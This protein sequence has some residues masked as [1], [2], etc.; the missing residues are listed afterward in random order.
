MKKSIIYKPLL[1]YVIL[2]FSFT[3]CSEQEQTTNS[4]NN[5]LRNST[6]EF[7]KNKKNL[8][9]LKDSLYR[10]SLQRR[11][12]TLWGQEQFEDLL[13]IEYQLLGY[14]ENFCPQGENRNKQISIIHNLIG[15]IYFEQE[16]YN[17][18]KQSYDTALTFAKE[19]N[20]PNQ[21][22][23]SYFNIGK[24]YYA[25]EQDFNTSDSLFQLA[26][27][28]YNQNKNKLPITA[29][30]PKLYRALAWIQ[31]H[32]YTNTKK[33]IK[34]INLAKEY[35][36]KLGNK[37]IETLLYFDIAD[38]KYGSGDV[39]GALDYC[40][41]NQ[42]KT[43]HSLRYER[44]TYMYISDFFEE[45]DDYKNALA[46]KKKEYDVNI[47][48]KNTDILNKYDFL[49]Q[50]QQ[51]KIKSI[52]A[53][54]AIE[55]TKKD[56]KIKLL[57]L[58]IIGIFLIGLFFGEMQYKE[59]VKQMKLA[60]AT[61]TELEYTKHKLELSFE[62]I[63]DGLK[64]AKN[65]QDIIIP[66]QKMIDEIFPE[67]FVIFKPKDIVSGDFYLIKTI[68]T[69][70][71]IA[72][73]DCTGHGVS[74]AFISIIGNTGIEIAI[75]KGA[76]TPADIL[77]ILNTYIHNELFEKGIKDSM[78]IT[79]ISYDTS[80]GELI[81]AGSKSELLLFPEH[82]ITVHCNKKCNTSILQTEL[83]SKVRQYYNTDYFYRTKGSFQHIGKDND[84]KFYNNTIQFNNGTIYLYSDGFADQLGGA[85]NTEETHKFKKL[86]FID[87]IQ[88]NAHKPMAEQKA[89]LTET[90]EKWQGNTE[91]TDDITL[92]GLR[93][94]CQG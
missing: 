67:N 44:Y 76:K 38:V 3:D 18:A 51:L 45:L 55:R 57:L 90:L 37:D 89:I 79:I 46:Y 81:Y 32:K 86:H 40:L 63:L 33:T 35:N 30:V 87:L 27:K 91:Q 66:K 56:R 39:K 74:G 60:K 85:N 42:T 52:E 70:Q 61:N 88:E 75:K 24:I 59:K 10:D 6:P 11:A 28:I 43:C 12:D 94:R 9:L 50:E 82:D 68:D 7:L 22:I 80:S 71:I 49:K 4:I 29:N 77:N 47:Q 34:Y 84:N 16:L 25:Y 48:M 72:Q 36:K 2:L 54:L 62:N 26:L 5:S 69:K 64:Y 19:Y 58:I 15:N 31:H 73:I 1:L 53:D 78:E 14:Y 17:K 23:E 92:I 93:L 65:I 13:A 20:T 21:L 41:K 83:S 8:Y